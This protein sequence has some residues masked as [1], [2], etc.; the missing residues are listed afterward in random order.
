[1]PSRPQAPPLAHP[2]SPTAID[3][4]GAIR[5]WL[6]RHERARRVGPRYRRTLAHPLRQAADASAPPGLLRRRRRVLRYRAAAA[7]AELLAIAAL[8]EH[9]QNP[10]PAAVLAVRELLRDRASPL[11][12]V[13]VD[14]AELHGTL[15]EL[16]DAIRQPRPSTRPQPQD[17][18]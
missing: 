18:S 10:D 15:K 13:A 16:R 2:A 3:D 7:R 8:L 9:A 12:D 1:M 14:V 5:R 4:R 6:A 11:Y 17:L